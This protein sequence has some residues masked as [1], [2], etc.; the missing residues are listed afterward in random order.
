MKSYMNYRVNSNNILYPAN[1]YF[2][3]DL[4]VLKEFESMNI[5]LI[6]IIKRF[7]ELRIEKR[8]LTF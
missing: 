1:L 6:K 8:I 7:V 4:Y 2:I 5:L 3:Y